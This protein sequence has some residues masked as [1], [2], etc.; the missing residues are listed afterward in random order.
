M[1]AIIQPCSCQTQD[2]IMGDF[3][4]KTP[5]QHDSN[6][7][8]ITQQSETLPTNPPAFSLPLPAYP[9]LQFHPFW[10]FF[11]KISVHFI[12]SWHLLLRGSERKPMYILIYYKGIMIYYI[13]LR[14]EKTIS[15]FLSSCFQCLYNDNISLIVNCCLKIVL[16]LFTILF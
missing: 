13:S 16:I 3:G 9:D 15:P 11:Q 12:L 5:H 2:T 6:F 1:P 10:A 14:R 7:W 4:S 8:R